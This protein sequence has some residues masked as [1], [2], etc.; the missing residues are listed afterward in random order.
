VAGDSNITPQFAQAI[1]ASAMGKI[2]NFSQVPHKRAHH[3]LVYHEGE[4]KILLAGGSTPLNGGQ[5]FKFFNDIWEYNGKGWQKRIP[6]GDERSG[7]RLTWDSKRNQLLSYG[8]FTVNTS[9]AELR[10]LEGNAWKILSN[11]PAMAAA[12]AG[13]VYDPVLDRLIAFGGSK[14]R[15]ESNGTTWVWDGYEWKDLAIPGP[16]G[17]QAFAMVYDSKRNKTILFGGMGADNK[18][19]KDTWELDG[20]TW[21]LADTTGPA[22]TGR[23]SPGYAYDSKRGLLI[24]FGGAGDNGLLGDT[25]SWD[26]KSWRKLSDTGP[27]PRAMGYM[28]YD[29]ER[30]RVVLFGGRAGWPNDMND[31]W[32]WDGKEWKQVLTGN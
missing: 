32:E 13:F 26:G 31:T 17:R 1:R 7:I 6:A 30:D 20:N 5:S 23:L 19:L 4:K 3:E 8:G 2:N 15:G 22:A 24:I 11:I 28:A 12:E 18:R 9:N 10:L 21:K 14:R 25:W 27:S 29:K 16:A